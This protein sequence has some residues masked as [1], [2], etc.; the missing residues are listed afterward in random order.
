MKTAVVLLMLSIVGSTV[1]ALEPDYKFEAGQ[2][3]KIHQNSGLWTYNQVISPL[4]ASSWTGSLPD[5]AVV[6]VLEV[7]E[8]KELNQ[9]IWLHVAPVAADG[10]VD[11]NH[12]VWIIGGYR[13]YHET[14]VDKM[15][16][17][18]SSTAVDSG[19]TSAAAQ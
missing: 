18:D 1:M 3:V 15:S 14:Y 17:T 19:V 12:A 9:S 6:R 11:S 16:A 4:A 2:T 5:G 10:T 13:K 8:P 7:Q